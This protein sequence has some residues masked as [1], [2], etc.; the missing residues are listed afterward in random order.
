MTCVLG[1]IL[2]NN[3][4]QVDGAWSFWSS[5]GQC[6]V[7]CG[8]G[9]RSRVRTCDNPA[10]A[11]GGNVCPGDRDQTITCIVN[12]C[13]DLL[14]QNIIYFKVGWMTWSD[15]S[16]CNEACGL[17]QRQRSRS[18]QN[19]LASLINNSCSGN[20]EETQI[21]S[22]SSCTLGWTSWS[23]W[24]SCSVA[25]GTGLQKRSRSCQ[26]P[27]TSLIND[28][29]SGSSAF[30]ATGYAPYGPYSIRFPSVIL[31][32]GND[33]NSATGVFTCRVP[34]LY[35]VTATIGKE[36]G[37]SV[38]YVPC[39]IQLNG[40]DKLYLYHDPNSDEQDGYTSSATGTFRLHSGWRSSSV[41][42]CTAVLS[43][44]KGRFSGLSESAC[45][46]S[47]YDDRMPAPYALC[48]PFCLQIPNSI[49][50]QYS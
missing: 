41:Y 23:G 6:D 4:T 8:N 35:L 2:G 7:T 21:C 28:S 36:F 25:C 29:C 40:S 50:N 37:T 5:W 3:G 24:T 48:S 46:S 20:A 18:C 15:W 11:H 26:N 13:P 32:E 19:P 33:Y 14:T 47:P 42:D 12:Q 30:T 10:P 31:N 27:M 38:E 16:S 43:G 45:S 49:V 17:G 44:S 34:G 1:F 22:S 39:Y 9:T